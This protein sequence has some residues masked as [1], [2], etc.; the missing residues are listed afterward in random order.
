MVRGPLRR[1]FPE[2]RR[3][4]VPSTGSRSRSG[5]GEIMS[6]IVENIQL[7]NGLVLEVWNLSRP[8]AADTTKVELYIRVRVPFEKSHFDDPGHF[9]LTRRVFGPEGIYEYR[10]E[11]T[12]VNNADRETV[13]AELLNGFR[14]DALPYFERADF[15]R[16]FSLNRHREIL[17][18]P[19]KYPVRLPDGDAT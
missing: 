6:K 1:L 12:F 13:F 4:G 9:D 2:A 5:Q 15:P 18:N 14:A 16:R 8:I 17:Q 11:R 3:A 7:S 19:W 10:K